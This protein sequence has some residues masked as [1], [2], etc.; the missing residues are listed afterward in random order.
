MDWISEMRA[1]MEMMRKA[2][3]KNKEWSKCNDCPFD[4]WCT[5]LMERSI[6]DGYDYDTYTPLNWL[7]KNE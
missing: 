5:M 7:E 2:C 4:E 1:G 6:K 3:K